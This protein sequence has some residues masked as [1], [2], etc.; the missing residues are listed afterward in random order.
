MGWYSFVPFMECKHGIV[1]VNHDL[2]G[3]LN[4][5]DEVLI[6]DGGKGYIEK[7]W[8]T[9]FPEA[10]IWMQSNNFQKTIPHS[11]FQWQKF[12]GLGNFLL[13]LFHSSIIIKN[14]SSSAPI[15]NRSVTKIN[16][17]RKYY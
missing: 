5:N 6:S 15:T 8:G 13:V 7:D 2:S 9:S 11:H 17:F 12:H 16:S 4:V 14:S 3:I 10:W 1:S